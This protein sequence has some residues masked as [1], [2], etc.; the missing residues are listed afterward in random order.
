MNNRDNQ[1]FLGFFI[2]IGENVIILWNY[3]RCEAVNII[4]II[5]YRHFDVLYYKKFL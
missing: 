3:S 1:L 4:Y 5:P 2:M